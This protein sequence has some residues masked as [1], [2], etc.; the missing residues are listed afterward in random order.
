MPVQPFIRA[1]TGTFRC[2]LKH[3][4]PVHVRRRNGLRL[5]AILE[6]I[7]QQKARDQAAEAEAA[8][9]AA[10]EAKVA[11]AAPE[12]FAVSSSGLGTTF[13]LTLFHGTSWERAQQIR[14][15]GFKL[16]NEGCLGRGIY[17]A[18]SAKAHGF[19]TS[20]DRHDGNL[21]A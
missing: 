2:P 6:F 20:S 11:A 1:C 7:R 12:E 14:S 15:G 13:T 8:A 10:L 16:S 9:T 18:D 21:G 19:A 4:H 5:S 3:L 17:F